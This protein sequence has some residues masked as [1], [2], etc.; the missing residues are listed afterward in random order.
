EIIGRHIR[1]QPCLH[2][3]Q[4]GNVP[5]VRAVSLVADRNIVVPEASFEDPG[6]IVE[7]VL[8]IEITGLQAGGLAASGT[9]AT[10]SPAAIAPTPAP[11]AASPTPTPAAFPPTGSAAASSPAA[12]IGRR[13]GS[14]LRGGD[15]VRVATAIGLEIVAAPI[16]R[17]CSKLL[18]RRIDLACIVRL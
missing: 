13:H 12:W 5:A 6:R 15:H 18:D 8:E 1:G 2:Q 4:I 3:L 10:A 16:R 7:H 9:A 11:P 17:I 14:R